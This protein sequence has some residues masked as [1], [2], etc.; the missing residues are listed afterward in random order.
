[1]IIEGEAGLMHI[2]GQA[3]G[4]PVKVGVAITDLTT[5][6]YTKGASMSNGHLIDSFG[7]SFCSRK[8]WIGP[9]N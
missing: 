2:T 4:E 1:M 3:D 7:C 6:L 5:G 8:D 9:K